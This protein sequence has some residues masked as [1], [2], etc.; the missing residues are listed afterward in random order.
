MG[1]GTTAA[2]GG[3]LVITSLVFDMCAVESLFEVEE[4]EGGLAPGTLGVDASCGGRS[5]RDTW[6]ASTGGDGF[7]GFLGSGADA[8]AGG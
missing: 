7:P 6:A 8:G 1:V 2:E 3:S 4:C 5:P